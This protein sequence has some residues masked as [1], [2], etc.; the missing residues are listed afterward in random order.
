MLQK[1]LE[2]AMFYSK[3]VKS[4]NQVPLHQEYRDG[5][6][7]DLFRGTQTNKIHFGHADGQDQ[8]A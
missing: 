6:L 4:R 8:V 7:K 3:I 5:Q 2:S 1:I